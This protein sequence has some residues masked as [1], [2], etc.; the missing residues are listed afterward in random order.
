MGLKPMGKAPTLRFWKAEAANPIAPHRLDTTRET[1]KANS[2]RLLSERTG[3]SENGNRQLAI[4]ESL[5]ETSTG[6]SNRPKREPVL[7]FAAAFMVSAV[8]A[9][10][11]SPF[12]DER[13]AS[14]SAQK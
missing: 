7:S 9:P 3:K 13:I 8:N 6:R 5:L 10:A 11:C 12:W 14:A 4:H 2:L 1:C